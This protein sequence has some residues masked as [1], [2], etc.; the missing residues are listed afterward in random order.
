MKLLTVARL[1]PA[2]LLLLTASL[3]ILP[4]PTHFFWMVEV[5]VTEWGHALA[6]ICL[7]AAVPLWS[8]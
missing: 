6:L 4:A 5:G 1:L 2:T 8:S 7:A 3:A